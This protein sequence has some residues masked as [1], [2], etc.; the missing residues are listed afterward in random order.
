MDIY[1]FY[2][3]INKGIIENF[4]SDKQEENLNLEFKTVSDAD[5]SNREDRKNFAIALSGFANSSGGIIVWGVIAKKNKQG[6]DCACGFQEVEPLPLFISKLNQFTGQFVN[7]IVE[8]IEHKKVISSGD[9][10]FAVS[11]IPPTDSGPHMAKAGVDRYFKRSGDSFYRMEHF[12]IEDMMGRRKKP[13]LSLCYDIE[14]GGSISGPTGKRYECHVIVGIKNLGRGIAKHVSLAL[15]LSEPY[16]LDDF[17]C[18][19][20]RDVSFQELESPGSNKTIYS[21]GADVVIHPKLSLSVALI[22]FEI[23][24]T[25]KDIKDIII[26]VEIMAEEMRT[27][28]TKLVIRGEEIRSKIIPKEIE[29][30]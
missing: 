23:W 9:K 8:G 1:E 14:R 7:P 6:I 25:Q 30:I 19:T 26:D 12:D 27:V 4:V 2:R 10:G 24:E 17:R 29:S 22:P 28:E 21:L 3:H 18:H 15:G 11:F 5:F 13:I 16:H 20:G